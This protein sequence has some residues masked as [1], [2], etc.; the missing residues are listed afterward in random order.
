MDFGLVDKKEEMRKT[1]KKKHQPMRQE[2]IQ[3]R[4]ALPSSQRK[5]SFKKTGRDQLSNVSKDKD[6]NWIWEHDRYW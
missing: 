1:P 6:E 4:T 2:E 3:E 5:R